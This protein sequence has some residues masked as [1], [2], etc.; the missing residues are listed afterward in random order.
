[1]TKTWK[2]L[3]AILLVGIGRITFG[4]SDDKQLSVF[5]L[6]IWQEGTMIEHGYDAIVQEIADKNADIVML[7]EVRNYQADFVQRLLRSLKER[8]IVYH[9]ISSHASLDVAL[10][11]KYPI[12]DQQPLYPVDAQIG[13]VLKTRITAQNKPFLFYSVH[14]DYT[15]YACYL[16]RGYDGVTWEKL[17]QP[18][19]DV[20]T[21]IQANRKSKRDEAIRDIIADVQQEAAGQ[22]IIIA[23]DFNEPSHLDW[24]ASTKHL[25]DHRGAVVPWDCSVLLQ[26]AQFIDA[27]RQIY[28]NPVTHPGFTFA[29][30]N[31]DAKLSDL[32]WA[33]E[34]DDRDRI[35]YIYYQPADGV[36]LATIQVV[37]P[38]ETIRYGKKQGKD[39]EDGFILPKG[40]WPTDHKGLLAHFRWP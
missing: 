7:S 2:I 27:F 25:F 4:Q 37:G 17:P 10:L 28:P 32:A 29:A 8:G 20:D 33:P 12:T 16:P 39:S 40:T 35:D 11:S 6:N 14:L 34:A 13:S 3:L 26:E 24:T 9:G 31:K 15:N 36:Y 23:G 19:S 38:V 22:T 1:M 5:Q 30:F 21:I 18:I